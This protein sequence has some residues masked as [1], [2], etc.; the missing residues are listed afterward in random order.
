VDKCPEGP[1]WVIWTTDDDHYRL[2]GCTWPLSRDAVISDTADALPPEHFCPTE[3]YS[4]IDVR[5]L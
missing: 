5:E 3:I 1:K 2:N 4:V